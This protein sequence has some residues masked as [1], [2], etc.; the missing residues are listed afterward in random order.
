MVYSSLKHSHEGNPFL[1]P[2]MGDDWF[3]I[4]VIIPSYNS[5]TT[6]IRCLDAVQNQSYGGHYE[7]ILVD[8]S[9]DGTPKIVSSNYPNVKF[10]HLAGKTDPGT[11]RNIGIGEAEGDLIAFV[12]SDCVPAR[13]WLKRIVCAHDS[14][15]DIIGGVVKNGNDVDDRVGHAG[16]ISEFREFLPEQPRREVRHI[17]TCN[18]SYKKRI[19][20]E[21]GLF[22]GDYYPQ[23]DLV[24]NYKLWKRGEKIL[25]DPAIQVFHHH[26]STLKDFLFHQNQIGKACSRVRGR[27]PLEGAFIARNPYLATVLIPALVMIKFFRTL[28]VF[29]RLQP[30][31]I[32]KQPSVLPVFALGLVYWGAGFVRGSFENRHLNGVEDLNY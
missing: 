17:P 31:S 22:Q 32:R 3:M 6:I 4:S 27:F 25:S 21:F 9:D 12:D 19:F 18:I 11:A 20:R 5:E 10:I 23:E 8:S 14:K 26:R 1:F 13:D 15:Y 2:Q 30:E 7:I 24:F 28:L 16:Y 29:S